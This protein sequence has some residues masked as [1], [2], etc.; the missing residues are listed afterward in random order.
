MTSEVNTFP[1]YRFD[2]VIRS[3]LKVLLVLSLRGFLFGNDL[4]Y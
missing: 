3:S 4:N 2:V 1:H